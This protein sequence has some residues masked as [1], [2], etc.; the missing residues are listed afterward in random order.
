MST[1][2][3]VCT[4]CTKVYEIFDNGIC[5]KCNKSQYHKKVSGI[6]WSSKVALERRHYA[7]EILQPYHKDGTVNE[8][9]KK[10]YGD[11]EYKNME[12]PNSKEHWQMMDN[13]RKRRESRE[14][15][16]T[17]ALGKAVKSR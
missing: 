10:V 7:K 13:K 4:H 5:S 11:K 16:F 12:A 3:R 14:Q 8:N 9:F 1:I 17:K 2:F 6:S 15:R